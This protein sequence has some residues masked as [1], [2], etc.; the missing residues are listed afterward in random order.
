MLG[1][2]S[3]SEKPG[4]SPLGFDNKAPVLPPLNGSLKCHNESNT[5]TYWYDAGCR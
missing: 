5:T 3:I 1:K 4:K 2:R